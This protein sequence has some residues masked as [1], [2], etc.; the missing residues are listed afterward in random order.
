[1]TTNRIIAAQGSC[2]ALPSSS[3][4]HCQ[5]GLRGPGQLESWGV[6]LSWAR[7]TDSK[8]K[9]AHTTDT[10]RDDTGTH[11]GRGTEGTLPEG[12]LKEEPP[13]WFS[14]THLL[15]LHPLPCLSGGSSHLSPRDFYN[16]VL[17]SIHTPRPT[18][19]SCQRMF[20]KHQ[21]VVLSCSAL[22]RITGKTSSPE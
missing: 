12:L 16:S 5:L 19:H 14:S 15:P 9:H 21:P 1:M 18:P 6:L 17:P 22:Q 8:L 11:E 3:P 2:Q 7:E 4:Y 10:Q 13:P 20:S